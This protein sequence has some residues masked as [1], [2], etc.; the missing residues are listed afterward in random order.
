MY[1]S[2]EDKDK[3]EKK[4]KKEKKTTA[5]NKEAKPEEKK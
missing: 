1:N 2:K 3:I 4:S 5:E